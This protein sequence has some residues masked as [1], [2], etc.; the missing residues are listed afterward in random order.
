I[1]SG[2]IPEN[3]GLRVVRKSDTGGL[4]LFQ[5]S[6]TGKQRKE[7]SLVLNDRTAEAGAVRIAIVVALRCIGSIVEPIVRVERRVVIAVEN[8]SAEVVGSGSC[9]HRYLTGTARCLGV[10]GR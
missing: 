2:P 4:I 1:D 10:H 9:D 5:V 7:E 8:A 3:T 6:L